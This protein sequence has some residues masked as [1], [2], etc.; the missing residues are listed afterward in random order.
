MSSG[1]R[2]GWAEI[3]LP[4]LQPGS[5]IMP[6]KVQPGDLRGHDDG[7][8]PGHGQRRVRRLLRQPGQPGAERDDAGDGAQR[9]GVRATDRE[10]GAAARRQGRRRDGGRLERT[11]EYAESSPSIVTR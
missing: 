3:H 1:P 10:R 2:T 9:A 7:L 8:R 5:S 6:G 11:R 4:D